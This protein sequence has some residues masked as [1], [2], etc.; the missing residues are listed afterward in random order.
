M[1]KRCVR[2]KPFD[3]S[4]TDLKSLNFVLS[5][6]FMKLF[7][8]TSMEVIVIQLRQSYFCFELLSVMLK[9]ELKIYKKYNV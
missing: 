8:T 1:V 6:F 3:L 7:K 9:K 2:G 4:A 5:R